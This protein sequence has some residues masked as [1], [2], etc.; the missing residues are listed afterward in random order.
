MKLLTPSEYAKKI[1][2]STRRVQLLCKQG[3][4]P[5]AMHVGERYVIPDDAVPT[6]AWKGPALRVKPNP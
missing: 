5:G 6:E 2:V 3:R 1:N 4:I